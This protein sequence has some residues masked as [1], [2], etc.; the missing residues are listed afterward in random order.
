[1]KKLSKQDLYDILYGCTILG[2]GGG[3]ELEEGLKLIDRAF[4]KGKE[5]ILVDLDEV[6]EEAM[7]ATPY[8]C[9]AI[10]P[11]TEEEK[12]IV[13]CLR[14]GKSRQCMLS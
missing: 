11:I 3:G 8:M 12:S 5:F 6:D 1:M 2:T 10:S 4:E 14:L 9:G 7:I 13:I